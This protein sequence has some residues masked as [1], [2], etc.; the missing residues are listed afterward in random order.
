[1]SVNW[2]RCSGVNYRKDARGQYAHSNLITVLNAQGEIVAQESGL[3]IR[4]EGI[5]EKITAA[6]K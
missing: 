2:P 5:A 4:T 1:M 6:A 3:N